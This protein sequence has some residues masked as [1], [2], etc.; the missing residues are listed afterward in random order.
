MIVIHVIHIMLFHFLTIQHY[1]SC[2]VIE[3]ELLLSPHVLS[4]VLPLSVPQ[5]IT[6]IKSSTKRRTSSTPLAQNTSSSSTIPVV[7]Q[8][9]VIQGPHTGDTFS[10]T[11]SNG[12]VAV[13]YKKKR[14]IQLTV[15]RAEEAHIPLIKDDCVSEKLVYCIN[16]Y[17][18]TCSNFRTY[19]YHTPFLSSFVY[20]KARIHHVR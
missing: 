20:D 8:L 18:C 9:Q 7:L 13:T 1:D 12:G 4:P 16:A 19:L 3:P 10:F 14:Y 5:S 2:P 15:G 17:L 6:P 11:T